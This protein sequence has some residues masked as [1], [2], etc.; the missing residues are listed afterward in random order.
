MKNST[1]R[2]A[3]GGVIPLTSRRLEADNAHGNQDTKMMKRPIIAAMSGVSRS[4]PSGQ[5]Q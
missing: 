1:N 4:G 3:E 5:R 2:R